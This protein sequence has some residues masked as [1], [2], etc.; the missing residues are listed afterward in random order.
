MSKELIECALYSLE[1]MELGGNS[2]PAKPQLEERLTELTEGRRVPL[3]VFNCLEFSWKPADKRGSYP[4]S[5]VS[6][7][8]E[9][10]IARYYS[11]DIEI[12]KMELDALG[13]TDLKVIV[14]DSELLDERV[15][16]FSQSREERMAV[17]FSS[18]TGLTDELAQLNG[19]ES[20][21]TLWSDYCR[22]NGL[23]TPMDYTAESYER[24]QQDPKLQKKIREQV[25]DSRKY[26]ARNGIS[27]D[28]VPERVAFDRTAWYLAMYMGEGQALAESRAICLNLEDGRVPAWFQR[29]ASGL[30]PIITPVNPKDFYSWRA[31]LGGGEKNGK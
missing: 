11:D 5:T 24:I 19:P 1:Q 17:A 31:S 12:V 28:D 15:F 16:S 8:P 27:M 25:K 9:L 21:V 3:V 4:R 26:L 2:L 30:L 29:G 7:N 22:D 20:P 23:S 10:S 13:S 18:R 14:P 6:C